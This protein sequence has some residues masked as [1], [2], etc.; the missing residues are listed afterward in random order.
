MTIA[1]G[2]SLSKTQVDQGGDDPAQARSQLEAIIDRLNSKL[3]GKTLLEIGDKTG[4]DSKV[5]SGTAAANG[6]LGLW[7]TDGDLVGIAKAVAATASTVVERDASGRSKFADPNVDQDA[8]NK[9]YVDANASLAL[10]AS[11]TASADASVAFTSG[12][13]GTYHTYLLMLTG[14][15]ADT[16]GAHLICE[17]STDGGSTWVNGSSDYDYVVVDAI[18]GDTSVNVNGSPTFGSIRIAE[19]LRGFDNR[20]LN[21]NIYLR[22]PADA[23]KRVH[24]DWTGTYVGSNFGSRTRALWGAGSRTADGAINAIR[25]RMSSGNISTGEFHLYGVR[26]A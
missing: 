3:A 4:A 24:L 22:H 8:A 11:A 15:N 18:A 2:T 5:V 20:P 14:V 9:G 13:D 25:F 12:I 17:V 23:N 26:K 1:F 10:I 7:N 6:Q 21:A 19:S 16:D